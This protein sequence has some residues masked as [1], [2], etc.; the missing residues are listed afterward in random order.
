MDPLGR[1]EIL[2]VLSDM[3]IEL[4]PHTKLPDSILD[5]RLQMR[6]MHP[7]AATASPSYPVVLINVARCPLRD[8]EQDSCPVDFLP[9]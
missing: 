4:P 3:G 8:S 5:K 9:S 1:E 2:Q 7:E 6:S